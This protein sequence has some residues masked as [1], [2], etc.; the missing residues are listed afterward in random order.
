MMTHCSI[1]LMVPPIG[2]AFNDQTATSNSFQKMNSIN[3]LTN[4]VLNEFQ[5][6][7]NQLTAEGIEVLIFDQPSNLPDAV[8]P[9][10]WFS[11]HITAKGQRQLFIYPML[12]PNRQAEVNCEGLLHAL[13]PFGFS[14]ADLIDLRT[15][16]PLILEGTG[17]LVLDREHRV[18]YACQS[19][20]T[21]PDLV[22]KVAETLGYQAVIFEAFD[23][24]HHP[25][26]HTNVM[27]SIAK[28]YAIV[29]LDAIH[30]AQ[31]K[32]IVLQHVEEHHKDLIELTKDQMHHLCGNVL[33]LYGTNNQSVLVLS[34]QAYEH[35]TPQQLEVLNAYS[36]LIPVNIPTIET[37]GGGSAR[38]MLAEI[39]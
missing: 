16:A 19:V 12:T 9:N 32:N 34:K 5:G 7:V 2:F 18:I 20:R 15:E 8:F 3:E 35:F 36:K 37:I 10:N 39:Y 27:M 6:M 23:Q 28:D 21:S 26:Y 17:S 38:C 4:T 13:Q 30:D 25:I 31:Q 24:H 33:E 29:C 11:T 22:H 1:V 14:K